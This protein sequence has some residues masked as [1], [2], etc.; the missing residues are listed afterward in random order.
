MRS[1]LVSGFCDPRFAD[2]ETQFSQAL[3]SG[4]ETGASIAVEHQGQMVVNLWGGHKD[5]AKTQPWREDTLVNVFS[6][7]KAV[8]ATCL[9]QLVE[10]G[11]LSLDDLV[12]DHWPEYACHGKEKT[13][14]SDFL[15]HRAAMHGFQGGVPK[16]DY[17]DW[18]AWTQ[19]LAAQ[20]PFRE[21]G[22]T[23]GYHA[24][25]Y[26]WLVGELIRRIDGRLAGQYFEE[27]IAKPFGLDFKIG[28]DADA[29][30][31]C[32]DILVDTRRS[33]WL[34]MVV[35]ATPDV[36]LP[37]RLRTLKKYLRMGDMK[38]AFASKSDEPGEMNTREWREADIPSASGHGTAAS[39]AKMFG[40][41]STGGTRD[42]KQLL[43]ETAINHGLTPLS[44]GPDTVIFGAPI[45]FGVGY[46]LGLGLTTVG[47]RPH[48]S[49]IFGHSGIGGSVAFGDPKSGLGY[50]FVGNRMHKLKDL[51]RTSNNL[52]RTVLALVS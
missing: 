22:S 35:A 19:V 24:L 5:R 9:L 4:F 10:Q 28:L 1:N 38:A 39:L 36:L 49:H 18:E 27:E 50:G 33:P 12:G 40:I 2:V 42:G 17:R 41:L 8:T 45:R 7:T 46:D 15:C 48:P 43:G 26:G 23:Q 52:T 32:G 34:L 44:N 21:P 31:R 51:Y 37:E 29:I 25:T 30:E 47:G 11:K 14:V 16:L 6:T 20:K 13:K 3:D